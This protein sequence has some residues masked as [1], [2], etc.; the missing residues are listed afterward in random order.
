VRSISGVVL[1]TLFVAAVCVA[2]NGCDE[3][4][5]SVTG[6]TPNL[7]PNI[8]SIQADIFT[9]SDSSGRTSCITCHTNAGGR[10]P[11]AGLNLAGDATRALV[12]VPSVQKSGSV[13]VIPGD[14]AN[15]YLIQKIKGA[16]GITGL[17]MPRNGPPYLTD[18][19]VLV[20]ERWIELG[21][22]Q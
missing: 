6:P 2:S 11:A 15:S 3:K 8:A 9:S 10:I 17:R 13:L 7:T 21:A 19:Q 12:N 4:L 18:G 20:I 1:R 5:S 16:G 22:N 14:P